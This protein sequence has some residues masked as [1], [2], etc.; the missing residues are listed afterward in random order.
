LYFDEDADARL[1][2]ALRRHGYDIETTVE[3]GVLEASDEAQLGHAVSQQRALVTHNIRHFPGIHAR[4]IEAG[5]AH[6]GI[7]VLI[8][9]S[10]MGVWLRRME[11]LL[12]RFSAEE[13]QNCL[14]FLGTMYDASV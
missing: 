3:A 11:N 1:A 4:W 12:H 9:H 14:F 8:G 10:A 6:G 13:L 5:Q 2:A 7:I